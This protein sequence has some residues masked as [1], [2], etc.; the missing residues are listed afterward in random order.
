M[1]IPTKCFHQLLLAPPGTTSFLCLPP[2][3]FCLE[4]K[5]FKSILNVFFTCFLV[6]TRRVCTA[7]CCFLKRWH[8]CLCSMVGGS[9]WPLRWRSHQSHVLHVNRSSAQFQ[10]PRLSEHKSHQT[11]L[12]PEKTST[13]HANVLCFGFP[14]RRCGVCSQWI[15]MIQNAGCSRVVLKN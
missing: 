10:G 8:L 5:F 2:R 3:G 13:A 7:P 11:T 14:E 6:G 15:T 9:A 4:F 1:P 12:G